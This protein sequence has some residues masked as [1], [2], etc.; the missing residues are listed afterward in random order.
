MDSQNPNLW[1][2][3]Q[4]GI[5]YG[6]EF[7][8]FCLVVRP[9]ERFASVESLMFALQK[10]MCR[11]LELDAADVGVSRRWLN[12]R[13]DPSAGVEIILYDRTPG[14]AGFVEEGKARWDEVLAAAIDICQ[15]TPSHACEMACYD[16]LKDFGNQ[17]YHDKLDRQ[18][19]LR[20]FGFLRP[21]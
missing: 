19:V 9:K 20:F 6:H 15:T 11:V 13:T 18:S 1:G 12:Q 21:A 10:G 8:S 4:H 16:C 14:G 17:S 3:G 7:R 5:A 2:T